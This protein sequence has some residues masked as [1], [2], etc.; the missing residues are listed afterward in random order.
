MNFLQRFAAGFIALLFAD[1]AF[2]GD[3]SWSELTPTGGFTTSIVEAGDVLWMTTLLD[4]LHRSNDR[5]ETWTATGPEA[6]VLAVSPH[7]SSVL[8]AGNPSVIHRSVDAG[9]TWTSTELPTS[10][11]FGHTV[12][13][14][15]FDPV[16][17]G[18]AYASVS[19]LGIFRT[20][21]NGA[22]WVALATPP[23]GS[24]A[25]AIAF[26]SAGTIYV[27]N[28]G[29]MGVYKSEDAGVNWIHLD[30]PIIT[31]LSLN[32][33]LIDPND[34]E[35]IFV[36]DWSG[37]LFRTV[38][39]GAT[40]VTSEVGLPGDGAGVEISD[41]EPGRV[42]DEF[43]VTFEGVGH[44]AHPGE[45]AYK[46]VDGGD[47]WTALA[48][49]VADRG[50]RTKTIFVDAT[51]PG[52][53]VLGTRMGNF[54]STDDGDTWEWS[55]DGYNRTRVSAFDLSD[56]T[57]MV[58][59]VSRFGGVLESDDAGAT[60]QH[61]NNGLESGDFLA[62]A[63]DPHDADRIV[64]AGSGQ[65]KVSTTGGA[66][67]STPTTALLESY[68]IAFDPLNAGVAYVVDDRNNGVWKTVDS[69]ANWMFYNS[70]IPLT[71]FVETQTVLAISP[72]NPSALY[73]NHREGVYK[74]TD[75]GVNWTSAQ[76]DL[77]V[78]PA[79]GLAVDPDD[80]DIVYATFGSPLDGTYRSTDGGATWDVWVG[81]PISAGQT[82]RISIDSRNKDR[83]LMAGTSQVFGSVDAGATWHDLSE[84]LVVRDSRGPRK[85][86]FDP[87]IEGR[88]FALIGDWDTGVL[89]VYSGNI[90]V[91]LAST[92]SAPQSTMQVGDDVEVNF[93]VSNLAGYSAHSVVV[94]I[95]FPV[96]LRASSW[97]FDGAACETGTGAL[98]CT[99]EVLA[100]DAELDGHLTLVAD[101]SGDGDITI[102][103][104]NA[105]TDNNL[106]N[107]SKAASL[108]AT[109][110]TEPPPTTSPPA[111]G[112][113]GIGH[114]LWLLA[115]LYPL[116]RVQR[117]V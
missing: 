104:S 98:A 99:I 109:N 72:T 116:R 79:S 55:N 21:D 103:V 54:V 59:V 102:E 47:N 31:S 46:T 1:G 48:P 36:S 60:W 69:G 113:G 68:E 107:N 13:D 3:R 34:D 115:L 76:G 89:Q 93:A 5:G 28:H 49:P 37:N 117:I 53:L 78:A 7:D 85:L 16:N 56:E 71:S 44:A 27:V 70:G 41:L 4:V 10:N 65:I 8:F 58:T 74:S 24:G 87:N 67:W 108:S 30:I 2:A 95:S 86:L 40:W 88:Y 80:P 64:A 33:I 96:N 39:G 105:D 106:E 22:T 25:R 57:D 97:T 112:G 6:A 23:P 61:R 101:A 17:P 111:S 50:P 110:P 9:A 19:S 63:R 75:G 12:L 15:A 43:Y 11:P 62:V 90:A 92:L 20:I 77:A 100:L 42:P 29:S 66:S 73:V 38:D 45:R 94:N 35:R 83:M 81:T 32:K 91:D 114:W 52:R 18:V 84:G 14:I 26:D 51:T 82:T